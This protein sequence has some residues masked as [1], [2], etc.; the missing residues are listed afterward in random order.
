MAF[1]VDLNSQY[2]FEKMLF[3]LAAQ[4]SIGLAAGPHYRHPHKG[5]VRSG[6]IYN[7]KFIFFSKASHGS[8]PM[9]SDRPS[10]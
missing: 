9:E 10:K 2:R 1:G 5:N 4:Q 3:S 7:P 6:V 8:V